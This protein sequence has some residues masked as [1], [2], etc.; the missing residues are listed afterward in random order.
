MLA[1]VRSLALFG[2][3]FVKHFYHIDKFCSYSS[4]IGKAA[5]NNIAVLY[6]KILS[7]LI[8]KG[9]EACDGSYDLSIFATDSAGQSKVIE[10]KLHSRV[11]YLL[12][13]ALAVGNFLN[14]NVALKLGKLAALDFFTNV[15]VN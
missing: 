13:L 8:R 15:V 10:G 2:M 11:T 14:L 12:E 9:S 4:V 5:V 1:I 6:L 3:Y 7:G